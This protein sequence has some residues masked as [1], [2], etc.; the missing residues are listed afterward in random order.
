MNFC[1]ISIKISTNDGKVN[2]LM[3][4][5]YSSD[6]GCKVIICKEQTHGCWG[7]NPPEFD[8]SEIEGNADLNQ[9]VSGSQEQCSDEVERKISEANE[10]L[11]A[12]YINPWYWL[13]PLFLFFTGF[14]VSL[15][16]FAVLA[17]LQQ[18]HGDPLRVTDPVFIIFFPTIMI[19]LILT[20]G[21]PLGIRS[22]RKNKEVKNILRDHFSDWKAKGVE[23]EYHP[24][25]EYS[26]G[27][28][29]L[30]LKPSSSQEVTN[31][32]DVRLKKQTKLQIHKMN[33]SNDTETQFLA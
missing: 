30:I 12:L 21:I 22:I 33:I 10:K 3:G 27:Y 7:I 11:K 18:K 8:S 25:N 4:S 19:F 24:M 9:I 16:C 29:K 31:E 26:E 6:A 32:R 13:A 2:L 23:V 28:L 1:V 5:T 14:T 17:G 20:I 15:L